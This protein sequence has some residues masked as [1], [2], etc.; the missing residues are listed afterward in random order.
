MKK[1][2]FVLLIGFSATTFF[3]CKKSK[4][5]PTA[6]T[7][8]GTATDASASNELDRVY[9]DI[10][11][12]F[13]SQQYHDTTVNANAR[14]TAA[15]LPCGIVS[16]NKRNFTITYGGVNCGSR[17]LSGSISVALIKGN[18]FS[19]QGAELQITYSNY[20]VLYYANNQ[21]LTYNGTA[22][23]TNTTGGAL[24]TLFTGAL[25]TQMIHCIRGNMTLTYDTTGT[26]LVNVT[27]AW[28]IFRLKTFT[29]AAGTATGITV[30]VAGDTSITNTMGTF[31]KVCE[32]G[33]SRDGYNFVC[34]MPTDF[35]WSNCGTD[36]TGPYKLKHGQIDY[37][38][39]LSTSKIAAYADKAKWSAI[40]G[41]VYVSPT[42]YNFDGTCS[43]DGYKLCDSLFKSN[44]PILSYSA[45]QPY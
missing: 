34:N 20:K 39:D 35:F 17:V 36:Y 6:S 11:T 27:R 5:E 31:T 33:V 16:L 43:V 15:I 21:S 44:V 28:N 8:S 12:V 13:N 1:I 30:D 37:V 26:G 32:T 9:S 19:D 41:Y 23:V 42:Q 22:Y 4:T 10:E 7:P 38:M 25:N 40:A 14:T 2:I 3:S 29:N 45:F 24:I 18:V